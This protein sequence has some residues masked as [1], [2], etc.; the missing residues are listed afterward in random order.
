[1]AFCSEYKM[2]CPYA[3]EL[4]SENCF[5]NPEDKWPCEQLWSK[6]KKTFISERKFLL[7]MAR[8]YGLTLFMEWLRRSG[9]RYEYEEVKIFSPLLGPHRVYVRFRSQG[10]D[11][12]SVRCC[13]SAKG[14]LL[15]WD[16]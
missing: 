5:C 8:F 16:M 7:G 15:C 1:M 13:F 2:E 6:E 10:Y 4:G 3:V 12:A 14:D 9:Y 11:S